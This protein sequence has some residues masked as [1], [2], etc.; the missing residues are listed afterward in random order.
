MGIMV[1]GVPREV[2]RPKTRGAAGPDGFWP[3]NSRGTP[4]TMI[5][6]RLFH[7]M[8]FFLNLKLV[9]F[10]FFQPMDSLGSIMVNIPGM[11]LDILIKLNP[12]I[13][14]RDVERMYILSTSLPCIMGFNCSNM[15]AFM[16]FK[17]T[18]IL[19]RESIG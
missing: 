1:N 12:I 18:T 2:P 5:P 3:W 16:V 14:G 19:P 11:K 4:V 7:I 9:K 6:L 17:L 15:E 8:S 13:L 10:D